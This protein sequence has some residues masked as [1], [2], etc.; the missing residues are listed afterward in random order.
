MYDTL[1]DEK[2]KCLS[3]TKLNKQKEK[4]KSFKQNWNYSKK[5]RSADH[6]QKRHSKRFMDITQKFAREVFGLPFRK[7]IMPHKKIVR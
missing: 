4:S 3:T 6:Q 5:W 1:I 7:V 2:Y